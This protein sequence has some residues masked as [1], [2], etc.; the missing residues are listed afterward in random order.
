MLTVPAEE[1]SEL[2]ETGDTRWIERGAHDLLDTAPEATRSPAGMPRGRSLY[3]SLPAQLEQP[4][5]FLAGLTAV[6]DIRRAHAIATATQIDIPHVAQPGMLVMVHRLDGGDR[7]LAT[8]PMQVTVLN[9]SGEA[10]EGTVHSEALIS[11]SDVIDASTGESIG[12]VDDLQSFGVSLPA[13]GG[14]FLLLRPDE[15]SGE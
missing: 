7:R 5:S 4:D 1:V 3:G 9:F 12:R 14:L 6:L 8:A 11:Q 2:I 15:P 13:Y 10:V